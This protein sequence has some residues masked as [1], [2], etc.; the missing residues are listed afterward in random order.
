M[1]GMLINR[2]H[3]LEAQRV[4]RSAKPAKRLKASI[5][6]IQFRELL[7][8]LPGSARRGFQRGNL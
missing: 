8:Q 6:D 7:K 3:A 2:L 4:N 1:N 5:A